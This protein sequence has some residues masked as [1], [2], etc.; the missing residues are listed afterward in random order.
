MATN[1]IAE[2]R[3]RAR[4]TVSELARRVGTSGPQITRLETSQRKLTQQWMEKIARALRVST[5]EL[6]SNSTTE[7]LVDEVEPAVL[8][9]FDD[10]AAAIASRGL[11]VYRVVVASVERAGLT[12]G[13]LIAVDQSEAAVAN[14][15]LGDVVLVSAPNPGARLLR[16]FVASRM[17]ITN[18]DGNNIAMDLS[19]DLKVIGVV[20]PP[21]VHAVG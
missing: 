19:E 20:I 6:I 17:V 2:L 18:H 12:P 3:K 9:G 10:V 1:R 15:K 7:P 5:T 11:H 13:Q 21:K 4:L 8:K 16:Q 14:I